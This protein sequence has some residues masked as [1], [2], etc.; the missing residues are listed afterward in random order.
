MAHGLHP[1]YLGKHDP[2]MASK[3]DGGM[4]IKHNANQRYAT[5]AVSAT[6]FRRIGKAAGVPVQVCHS[7]YFLF[8]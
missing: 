7:I 6:L 8:Q 5:S 2:T 4:V 1:N 3:I